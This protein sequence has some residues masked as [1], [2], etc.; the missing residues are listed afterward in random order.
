MRLLDRTKLIVNQISKLK[1]SHTILYFKW[2]LAVICTALKWFKKCNHWNRIYRGDKK[3]VQLLKRYFTSK[4]FFIYSFSWRITILSDIQ[5]IVLL[6]CGNK[7]GTIIYCLLC[8]YAK[9]MQMRMRTC[10]YKHAYIHMSK[11]NTLIV[12]EIQRNAPTAWRMIPLAGL[13]YKHII[14]FRK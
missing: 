7:A 9:N 4:V 11:E 1:D 6:C 3:Y 14:E 12:S 10:I 2:F 5:I 13:W 8:L